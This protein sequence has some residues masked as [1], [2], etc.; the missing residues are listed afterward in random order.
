MTIEMNHG[1]PIHRL[2]MAEQ[3]ADRLGPLH[4]EWLV[5]NGSG[6]FAMGSVAGCN[7]RRYHGH[8]IAA[9]DPPVGRVNALSHIAENVRFDHHSFDLDAHEFATDGSTT[10]HP[11]GWRHLKT[12]EKTP[13]RVTW[14][15]EC[16][17]VH[18]E[19]TLRLVWKRQMGV[20][21]YR[22][23]FEGAVPDRVILD[24]RP[25]TA[26]RDFH[27]TQH[28]F[29]I[30]FVL[31]GG[32]RNVDVTSTLAP[33]LHLAADAG[34]FIRQPDWWH[35]F[36]YRVEA[37]RHQDCQESLFTPGYFEQTID[38]NQPSEIRLAFGIEP[39]DWQAI[40]QSPRE[41]HL[42]RTAGHV[43]AQVSDDQADLAALACA[44]DDFVVDRTVEGEPSTTIM[45]G[46]PWFS[47]WGR[48]T[49]IA[50]PG[51]LLV[52]GRFA[53]ARRTLLTF[54]AHIKHGLIPNRFDDYGGDPHYNT[55]DASLWF[56]HAALEYTRISGDEATWTSHLA[57]ACTQIIDGYLGDTPFDIGTDDD[58]LVT[59]GNPGTQLTWM[60]AARDGTVFTPRYGKAV[61]INALWY[62]ALC[63][64]AQRASTGE[65]DRLTKLATRVKRSFNAVFW[66]DELGY[67]L[68]HVNA[69]YA[70]GTCRPNQLL[71]V[72][73][74]HSPLAAAK[75]KKVV[76]AV[77]DRLLT[78]MGLRTLPVDDA[79]YHGRYHG[80]MFERDRA[81]HQGT[82]WA[83]PIGPFIEG[84]LRAH[85]FSKKSRTEASEMLAPLIE[86]LDRGLGQL[87]E[88]FDGDPP[89]TPRGCPAQAWSVS[90]TLRAKLLIEAG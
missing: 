45:A 46:Y 39:I 13:T 16:G 44:S 87:H 40:D 67:L 54:A 59:A 29:A 86:Q 20:V 52:T 24:L 32:R 22:L 74:P 14:R 33:T 49:M 5:T 38:T 63:G 66:S 27:A 11:Q 43:T 41:D 72:S 9:S 77:R 69:D 23:S 2:N 76:T 7:I 51:C 17:P 8:L 85:K 60:D 57:D 84:W 90:E 53:E 50:L 1:L 37:A 10:F 19:K 80:T 82:V 4:T 89:H 36:H 18:I 42:K 25:F 83:W 55:V 79:R 75:Q 58:G 21:R 56:I 34:R 64:C 26:M 73:L 71:A 12:F 65:A 6:A 62:N 35:R 78:P 68:D 31:D 3:D 81:Y 15:Y 61:E 30:P 88:I 47:D 70:D 48:D 28:A